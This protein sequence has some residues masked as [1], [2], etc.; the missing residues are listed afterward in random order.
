VQLDTLDVMHTCMYSTGIIKTVT[1]N[2]DLCNWAY[3]MTMVA[4]YVVYCG[5]TDQSIVALG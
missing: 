1:L 3:M 2:A 4:I 5:L